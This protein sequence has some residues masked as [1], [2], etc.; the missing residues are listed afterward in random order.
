MASLEK[1]LKKLTYPRLFRLDGFGALL[2]ALLLSQVL[3]R[4]ESVFGMPRDI[5]FILAGTA[6]CFAVYSFS[7]SLFIKENGRPFLLGIATANFIYC[8]VTLSLV[9]Y[10][11]PI[12]TG[13]G[14]AY[15]IGEIL[16]VMAL[17]AVEL[18]FSAQNP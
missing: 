4:F 1:V 8:L 5:L 10:L 16:L 6:A 17:V 11:N 13:L 7:C 2:T 3:A 12:L 18:R 14:M 9:I 15:F